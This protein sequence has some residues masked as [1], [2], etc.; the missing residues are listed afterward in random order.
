M[1]LQV[2]PLLSHA[3]E[4]IVYEVLAFLGVILDSN[5]T[6]VQ[7][8]LQD[9]INSKEHPMFLTLQRMLKEAAIAYS[10]R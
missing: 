3:N 8:G 1:I 5:N 4:E 9:L 6:A 2:M 10:E 7:E